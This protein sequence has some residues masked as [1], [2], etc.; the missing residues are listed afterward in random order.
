[1]M[2]VFHRTLLGSALPVPSPAKARCRLNP[3]HKL[4]ILVIIAVTSRVTEHG[5]LV[6]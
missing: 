4:F 5:D 1:M 3:R 2:Q 6:T